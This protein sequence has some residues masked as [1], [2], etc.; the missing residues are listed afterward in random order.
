MFIDIIQNLCALDT[1]NFVTDINAHVCKD[2][3]D[4]HKI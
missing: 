2:T 3:A 1:Q 4:I